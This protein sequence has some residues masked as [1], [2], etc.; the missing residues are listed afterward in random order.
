VQS[1]GRSDAVH[2][3]LDQS[4]A[5][6]EVDLLKA[7]RVSSLWTLRSGKHNSF[8]YVQ[9]KRPLLSV[10]TSD[11]WR[12]EFLAG[13]W[14]ALSLA[15]RRSKLRDL[16][17]AYPIKAEQ[18]RKWP[19]LG[20][21]S[22]LE[23][24]RE[25]V[26][27]HGSL[28]EVLSVIDRFLQASHDQVAFLTSLVCLLVNAADVGDAEVIE[29]VRVALFGKKASQGKKAILGSSLYF[30]VARGEFSVDVANS[31]HVGP[32]SEAL[33]DAGNGPTNRFGTCALAGENGRLHTGNFPQPKLPIIGQI[34]LFAKNEDIRAAHRY[35]RFADDAIPVGFDLMQRLAGALDEITAEHRKGQTWRSVP[36]EKPK[37]DL[38]LAFVDEVSDIPLA[39]AVG[40]DEEES[41]EDE[42]ADGRAAFLTRTERI[43]DAVKAK[44]GADFRKT[45]VT[46]CVLR[47][48][49]TGNAKMILHRAFTIGELYDAAVGWDK[50][51][52]NV[53]GW[54][55]MPVPTKRKALTR[56]RAPHVAPLQLPQA[57]RALFIR[58]GSEKA[59]REP[60]GVTAQDALTLF[61]NDSGA[62]RVGRATLAVVLERQGTLL[63]GATHALRKDAG[64]EKLNHARKFDPTGTLRSAALRTVTL[65]GLLLAKL[66]REEDYMDDVP[67]KLGQLL[68]VADS[69]HVGYCLDVRR[70]DVP[71]TLLG[72]SML[73]TAQSDPTKALAV[74]SRRW[75][76]YA[77]WAK[78]PKVYEEAE[79]LRHSGNKK[80]QSRGWS[81][82]GAVSR[83]RRADELC[84]ELHGQLPQKVDD[85]FRAELLLGY[86]AGL[87]PIKSE[88]KPGEQP[89][90]E[91]QV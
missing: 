31:K 83:A 23:A 29:A 1:P 45:P 28:N 27:R 39:N 6:V 57:T 63:S 15:D 20:L 89:N 2:V 33:R 18:W 91:D 42:A 37:Q 11:Q 49:D 86:V 9:L 38:L 58:G 4:G 80:E 36:S 82:L 69:V 24:R 8:P 54:L 41:D 72:N 32:L 62:E 50:A 79:R 34:Y 35:G 30:D 10:P 66:G 48:V 16:A 61:L 87:P 67:F 43:I 53:P 5:P 55:K 64:G 51:Q 75:A 73:A 84:R 71:P 78:R 17:R 90:G 26:T 7:D 76:P 21:K 13:W 19:G 52:S 81:I 25:R 70:G 56:R 14:R 65:L 88:G 12:D 46:L 59:R 3:R 74:L 77:A 60:V 44:V 68:A 22:N 40:S 47:K 85:K